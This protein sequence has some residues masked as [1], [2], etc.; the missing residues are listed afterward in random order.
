MR[1]TLDISDMVGK[2]SEVLSRITPEVRA[3]A[4][5]WYS[6]A[7]TFAHGLCAIRTDWNLATAASVISALSPRERWES[8]KA[9]ALAFAM[10]AP[11]RGLGRNIRRAELASRIGYDALTGPKTFEF[12][13]AIAGDSEAVVIDTWMLKVLGR[14]SCTRKQYHQI[15]TAVAITARN[16]DMTPREAQAAIWIIVRGSPD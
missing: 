12:A 14:K 6:G 13:R 2:Y 15:A 5:S 1:F 8:N 7:T 11:I 10:G 4:E 3:S 16:F 9:K